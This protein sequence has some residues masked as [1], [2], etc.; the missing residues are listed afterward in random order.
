MSTETEKRCVPDGKGHNDDGPGI[1]HHTKEKSIKPDVNSVVGLGEKGNP[2]MDD[3]DVFEDLEAQL[4]AMH[5]MELDSSDSAI[6]SD[7]DTKKKSGSQDDGM[8]KPSSEVSHGLQKKKH[9]SS[10]HHHHHE[11]HDVKKTKKPPEEPKVDGV[12]IKKV[13]KS[14]VPSEINGNCTDVP[15]SEKSGSELKGRKNSKPSGSAS[16]E[17]RTAKLSPVTVNQK[18]KSSTSSLKATGSSAAKSKLSDNV[19]KSEVNKAN[20][21]N[22]KNKHYVS[23]WKPQTTSS[24]FSE[25]ETDQK[26]SPKLVLKLVTSSTSDSDKPAKKR[27]RP[28]GKHKSDKL[29]NAIY[30]GE[31]H[32]LDVKEPAHPIKSDGILAPHVKL[33]QQRG[34][35]TI[36]NTCVP[37]PAPDVPAPEDTKRVTALAFSAAERHKK[38]TRIGFS[39]D[40]HV[41][42]GAD[43]SWVCAFCCKGSHWGGMGDLFGPYTLDHSKIEPFVWWQALPASSTPNKPK[44]AK[45]RK[46]DGSTPE[47]SKDDEAETKHQKASK[48]DVIWLHE[49]CLV[50][51][52]GICLIGTKLHGLEEALNLCFQTVCVSCGDRGAS[53]ECLEKNCKAAYH[54]PCAYAA[55]CDLDESTFHLHCPQHKSQAPKEDD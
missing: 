34:K 50:W 5:G 38:A 27:G 52:P 16:A 2:K 14:Y 24:E 42:D 54:I 11:K 9:D 32:S 43:T 20:I 55:D 19:D 7:S 23:M 21:E 44:K 15:V 10:H 6:Q 39:S 51:A 1:D 49:D 13:N 45:K 17:K 26:E 22:D 12:S 25:M 36:I 8:L 47:S 35:E 18:S 41:D 46:L 53:V 30:H 33:G 3:P 31:E 29:S 4:A 28:K 37:T 48:K 40:R